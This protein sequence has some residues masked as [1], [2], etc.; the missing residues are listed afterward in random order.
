LVTNSGSSSQASK[1]TYNILRSI[2]QTSDS[3]LGLFAKGKETDFL[4]FAERG[5]IIYC[6]LFWI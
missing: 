5:M 2:L 1:D 6:E 3:Q 4:A